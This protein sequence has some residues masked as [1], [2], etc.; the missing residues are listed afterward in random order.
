MFGF[1]T[2]SATIVIATGNLTPV[3]TWTVV[4]SET[5]PSADDLANI[6]T[7]ETNVEDILFLVGK[8]GD[9]I[10]LKHQATGA[11]QIH[12]LSA[13]DKV[14]DTNI[15]TILVRRGT[16]WYEFGGDP[17]F[18]TSSTDTL[19]NKTLGATTIAGHLIPDT[20]VAYD[21]GSTSFKFRDLY[22][23]GSSIKLGDATITASASTIVLPS[24]ST[25]SG[26]NGDVV[27]LNSTQTLTNKTFDADGTGNSITNIENADIK[28]GAGIDLSKLATDPLARANHT[29]TQAQ[30]TVTDLVS[31][32]SAKAPLAS[33]TFTGTV[34]VPEHIQT[35]RFQLDKG[36]DVAS[37]GIMTLGTDGNFFDITGTTTINEINPTNWQ[38]GSTIILQFDGILQVT[39]NSGGTNDILLGDATN[40]TTATGDTLQLTYDG[41]DWIETGGGG[42]AGGGGSDT[43]WTE[44]H[45]FDNFYFDMQ[46][47]TAPADPATDNGRIY[48][49]TI[50]ANNDG[51]F[52]K[53]KKNGSFVEVQ[54][55]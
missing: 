44:N 22:L 41:I 7:T 5:S 45:D 54:I 25:I 20:D 39:H 2:T 24:G 27:D 19:T 8:S 48:L 34:T 50:D 29:G 51:L 53:V 28:A 23:S 30:S 47:Q 13:S 43:P 17:S 9:T 40:R 33:P 1:S 4:E 15:P 16:D 10:T 14:L 21:L 12:I 11:G 37:A 38:A 36:A 35:G 55:A 26:G 42:A 18:T 46:V 6:L 3:D 31:D 52:M 32:L 49:K